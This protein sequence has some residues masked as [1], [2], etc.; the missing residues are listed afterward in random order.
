M[1]SLIGLNFPTMVF[2]IISLFC[3][4]LLIV[5][6]NENRSTDRVVRRKAAT[7]RESRTSAKAQP[8]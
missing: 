6:I 5:T 3:L 7:N 8:R 1:F 2:V 4:L